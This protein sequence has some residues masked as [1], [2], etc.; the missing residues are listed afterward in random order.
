MQDIPLPWLFALLVVL[1]SLSAFLPLSV[2]YLPENLF[3]N[4]P[5]RRRFLRT[6]R[7]EFGHIEKWLRRLALSRPGVGFTLT[8]DRR[9]VLKLP[10]ATS[11]EQQLAR[12]ARLC[13][14][15]FADQSIH[16]EHETD[17]IALEG[18]VALP[19]YNR[20]QPDQ[21]YWFVNGRSISDKTLAHAAK[22]AYRDVLFHG[23]FPAY[24]LNLAMD[25]AGVRL[26][27]FRECRAP[28]GWFLHGVF[29]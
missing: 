29:G 5:A 4:T 3:Y 17:G 15:A 8:H 22:H 26:W 25:P 9:T 1:V 24:V 20:S 28:Q 19:T 18:W 2:L 16:V 27:I 10:A 6:E 14:D 12:L 23:R 11:S 7:T 21:Q 13:G